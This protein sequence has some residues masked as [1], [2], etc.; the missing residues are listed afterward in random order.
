[1]YLN[2]LT[3]IIAFVDAHRGEE[4]QVTMEWMTWT[5]VAVVVIVGI[6]ALMQKLGVDLM[7]WMRGQLG[8]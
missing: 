5:F 8:L 6:M 1:M 4:G 2:L 3:R 7:G